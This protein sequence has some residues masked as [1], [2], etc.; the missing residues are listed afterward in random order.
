MT[1]S[2]TAAPGEDVSVRVAR[3]ALAEMPEVADLDGSSLE[4]SPHFWVGRLRSALENLAA[5]ASPGG[6]DAGQREVL[7]AA[8]A[9][10]IEHRTSAG[11]CEDCD[12]RPEGLCNDHAADLDLTDAYIALSRELGIEVAS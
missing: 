5:V 11:A 2:H 9:D 10:A 12:T 3:H 8:L 1:I 6:M 7:A 4:R